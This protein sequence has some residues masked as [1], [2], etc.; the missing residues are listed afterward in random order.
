MH[1]NF[2]GRI[3]Q[4]IKMVNLDNMTLPAFIN[5]HIVFYIGHGSF[6]HAV[7]V[8]QVITAFSLKFVVCNI[9]PSFNA[10]ATIAYCTLSLQ[11]TLS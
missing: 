6:V 5:A 7:I 2:Q 1:M 4:F 9:R 10:I 8:V 3:A 11:W